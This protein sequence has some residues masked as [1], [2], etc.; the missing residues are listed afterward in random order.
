MALSEGERRL[1]DKRDERAQE[2]SAL[3]AVDRTV[4]ARERQLEH[5]CDVDLAVDDDSGV[6]HRANGQDRD[7]W[8]VEHG[9]EL[10]DVKHAEVRDRE[11]SSLEVG[12]RE[13]SAS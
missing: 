6:F 8:R 13:L 12:K 3:G 2:V 4:V 9:N 5:R 10:L 11:R 1:F 7:L